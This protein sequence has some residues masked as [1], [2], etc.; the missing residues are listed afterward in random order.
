MIELEGKLESDDYVRAVYLNMRP[1]RVYAILGFLVLGAFLWAAWYSFFGNGASKG[2]L[3]NYGFLAVTAYL[4]LYF[5][6]YVPWKTRR[7]FRQQK[8]L[9]RRITWNFDDSGLGIESETGQGRIPWADIH[10]WKENDHLYL[11]Y[12]SDAL[13]YMIPKRLFSSTDD[14]GSVRTLLLSQVGAASP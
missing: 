12:V 8:S 11:L 3:T 4:V 14:V 13:Y 7:T 2:G 10:K 6:V 1:R 5:F 9:Q